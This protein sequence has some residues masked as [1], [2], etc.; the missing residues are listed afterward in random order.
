MHG[1][2]PTI[3]AAVIGATATIIVGLLSFYQ[4]RRS[5]SHY[6]GTNCQDSFAPKIR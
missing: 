3:V 5:R 1:L 6:G 4:T 2:D